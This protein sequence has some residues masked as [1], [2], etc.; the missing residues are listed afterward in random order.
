MKIDLDK[1]IMEDI[2]EWFYISLLVMSLFVTI[3][4]L[5]KV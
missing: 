3:E 5:Y 2:I 1:T 4:F